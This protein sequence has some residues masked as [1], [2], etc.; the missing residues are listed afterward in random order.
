MRLATL[1][2]LSAGLSGC[3]FNL[4]DVTGVDT[5]TEQR[6]VE[7]FDAIAVEGSVDVDAKVGSELSV[8]IEAA[9]KVIDDI[10][11]TVE[12]GVL[13]IDLEGK[14]H[15][16]TGRMLV[17]VTVPSLKSLSL[18]GSGDAQVEGLDEEAFAIAVTGSGDV[19][20]GGKAKAV[21]VSLS[22][23][24][25]VQARALEAETADITLRGSGDV[26]VTASETATGSIA[27]SGDVTVHGGATC[28]V[29][30]S[31]SGDLNC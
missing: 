2:C 6:S 18:S 13:H 9:S 4:G 20:A 28:T 8:E 31:G 15:V 25:D 1:V 19:E 5:K 10:K 14:L 11:T 27:G 12:D 16:N 17:R 29:A 22:G 24:G 3:V 23:S 30:V 26:R 7:A 21:T